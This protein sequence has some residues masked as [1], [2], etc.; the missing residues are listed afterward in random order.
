MSTYARSFLSFFSPPLSFDETKV[1]KNVA[2]N[3]NDLSF[4]H[5]KELFE[6]RGE[7]FSS[8]SRMISV[9]F[10]WSENLDRLTDNYY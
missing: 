10:A 3:V 2:R 9:P 5:R 4:Y 1:S 7:K 8:E 6:I